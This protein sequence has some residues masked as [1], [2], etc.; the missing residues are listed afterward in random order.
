M[1][2]THCKTKNPDGTPFC[3]YCDA[4]LEE[5]D[6][7]KWEERTYGEEKRKIPFFTQLAYRILSSPR[8]YGL[9]F[10]MLACFALCLSVFVM[11]A[12]GVAGDAVHAANTLSTLS[13]PQGIA[14]SLDAWRYFWS[15]V[16]V[17]LLTVAGLVCSVWTGYKMI[18]I[19]V[20]FRRKKRTIVPLKPHKK[21][22]KPPTSSPSG[23]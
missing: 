13:D 8:R 16:I 11:V 17:L 2:C 9:A 7:A 18:K 6:G 15:D 21:Q 5:P 1:K 12:S 22:K 10:G 14:E 3:C 20:V 19:V 4:P 23:L